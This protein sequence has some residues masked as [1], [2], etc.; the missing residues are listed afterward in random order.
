M[1]P[2]DILLTLGGLTVLVLGAEGMIRGAVGLALRARISPLV[3]GLTVVSLGTSAP[4]LLVSLMAALKGSSVMAVGN[5]VGSNIS[6]ISLVLGAC[7]LVH[8]IAVDRDAY[9]IHWP[10]MMVVSLLFT[11]LLWDDTVARWE[12]ALFVA[13]L[14]AYVA[15]TVWSSRRASGQP[16]SR[17][18]EVA[19]PLWRPLLLL[20]VG[21]VGLAQGA[22]WF[23][24]GAVRIAAGL[25]VSDQL[26]GVTV[27]AVGT[28]LPELV[29]SLVAALRKQSDISIGNLLG[30]NTF[31]LLGIIGVSSMVLPIRVDHGTFL[32]D[33]GF[34]LGIALVLRPLMGIGR[35]LG[36]WQGLFLF[37]A[38]AAYI[39]LVL[40]RG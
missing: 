20:S 17:P 6:N 1:N 40:Q 27:V 15:W 25:G 34:M 13:L 32:L 7:V 14:V 4:E 39:V 18:V 28:S 36:R 9:R 21:V 12:G 19:G 16:G 33:L 29:T 24:E 8:P 10:V 23:V 37:A 30:S 5:V 38:Y 2:I 26:I 11:A 22:D 31:N 35:R 3:V